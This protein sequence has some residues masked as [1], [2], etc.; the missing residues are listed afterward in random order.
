MFLF[1]FS[2]ITKILFSISKVFWFLG[3]VCE[4]IGN[5]IFLQKTKIETKVI[6]K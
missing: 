5:R 6:K 4:K 2:K 1:D 3:E